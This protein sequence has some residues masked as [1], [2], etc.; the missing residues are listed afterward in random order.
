MFWV[1]AILFF[2][3]MFATLDWQ[4]G[5]QHPKLKPEH[6]RLMVRY[7]RLALAVLATAVIAGRVWPHLASAAIYTAAAVDFVLGVIALRR[8]SWI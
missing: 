8:I 4:V 6:R 7:G 3:V 1:W 5:F 2:A